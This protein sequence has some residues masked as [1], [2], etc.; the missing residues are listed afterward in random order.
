MSSRMKTAP[1]RIR[2]HAGLRQIVSEA[3]SALRPPPKLGLKE[4]S[5]RERRL[6]QETSAR[7]GK[8][9]TERQPLLG[10]IMEAITDPAVREVWALKPSQFGWTE[11]VNNAS[12]YYIHQDPTSILVV[13][14]TVDMAEAWSKDRLAPMIRD[15]PA[16]RGLIADPKSRNSGNSI[17]HKGFPGGQIDMVGANAPAGLASRPK[18]IVIYDEVDRYPVSAGT[19]GDPIKLARKRQA[20]FWNR[21]TLGGS[22]PTRKGFSRIEREYERSDMRTCHVACSH[23][24]TF[25]TL[26]WEQVKWDKDEKGEHKP[27][28]AH[29]QCEKCG[30]L[31]T[32]EDRLYAIDHRK[33]VASKP[34]EGIAGFRFNA[35]YS[36]LLEE[37]LAGLVREFLD[38]RHHPELLQTFVNTVLGESWEEQGETLDPDGFLQRAEGF[39]HLTLP[40]RVAFITIGVD[41]QDDRLEVQWIGWG[42]GEETWPCRYEVILG[43]PA[44]PAV[45]DKLTAMRRERLL[46][47]EGRELRVRATCI[48]MGGHHAAQVLSYAKKFAREMVFAT[49]GIAGPR[50]IWPKRGTKSKT[51]SLPFYGIGV[52]TAKDAIYGRL[53]IRLPEGEHQRPG[54]VHFPAA[55]GFDQDYFAQLTSE[56][57]LTRFRQGRPY[58]V[59][60]LPKGRRNEALDTF[61]LA[62]AARLATNLKLDPGGS[63]PRRR[64]T[65]QPPEAVAEVVVPKPQRA[66]RPVGR[67]RSRTATSSLMD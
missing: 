8:W 16:L 44:Q 40:L 49:K 65:V 30:E 6:S 10:D 26:R 20:T 51:H 24:K 47:D 5:E 45:W 41:V 7:P 31:W 14:P 21:K 13:Q 64:S 25:Q 1:I 39:D 50:S 42:E 60:D 22:T 52:D 27:N 3:I 9:R 53:K 54:Y 19:E 38:C 56:Q 66:A 29:Y 23:C 12:G 32:E 4:W 37:G 35:I 55:D 67:R 63:P 36:K 34:F 33:W 46:N 58:R 57:V 59:W 18:R 11:V 17:L 2:D 48:D 28:T 61:V 62:M 43:D 15:T